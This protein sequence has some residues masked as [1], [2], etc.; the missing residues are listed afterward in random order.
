[1]KIAVFGGSISSQPNSERA[2]D[3]WRKE[4]NAEVITYGVGGMGFSKL[5]GEDNIQAQVEKAISEE[6]YDIYVFWASNNDIYQRHPIGFYKDYTEFDNFDES[7]LN[8][9][10]GG[11]NYCFKRVF[12]TNPKAKIIFFTTLKSIANGEYSYDPFFKGGAYEYVKGQIDVCN[13]WGIP[14]LN[15]FLNVPINQYNKNIY[16][17][18]DLVH[19]TEEGYAF[20][21]NI[22]AKFIKNK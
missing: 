16:L 19:M 14:C 6:Q 10:A 11:M 18:E 8:S 3:F 12:E 17:N 4:L 15:Q 13:Y 5:T 1:M 2:K 9:Q 22:Q 21:G 20:M 7:K